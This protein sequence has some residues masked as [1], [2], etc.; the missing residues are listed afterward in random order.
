MP[1]IIFILFTFLVLCG[2]TEV[3]N[4]DTNTYDK[5]GEIGEKIPVTRAEV[6]K[7][8]AL[9]RF[10]LDDIKNMER[11][12]KFNDTDVELWYDKYINASYN[13]GLIAGVSEKEFKPDENLTLTQAQ[14]LIKKINTRGNFE[15]KYNEAD[16]DKPISYKIWLEAFTKAVGD[17]V[18]VC[19]IFVYATDK[20]CSDLGDKYILCN[21]GLR[22]AE[23]VDLSPYQD[24]IISVV[25]KDSEIV[26][27]VKITNENPTLNNAEVINSTKGSITI[28]LNGA[29]RKFNVDNG[30]NLFKIGDKVDV[31]FKNDG[32]YD[33]KLNTKE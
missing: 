3:K 10:S 2:C 24:K 18:T 33:I 29:E 13:A 15:L 27:V 16:K 26:G 25:M 28:K 9:S 17:K 19:D 8:L 7:M 31:S 1:R 20:F 6:S 21:G 4:N 32:E 30:D 22:G 5:T 11:T 12:I 23:G 14:S